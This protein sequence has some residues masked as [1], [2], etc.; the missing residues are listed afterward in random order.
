M[1]YANSAIAPHDLLNQTPTKTAKS[2]IKTGRS[3]WR[4]VFD[5]LIESRMRQ[6]EREIAR[7][8]AAKSFSDEVEREIERRFLS[9]PSHW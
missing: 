6:A 5:A 3:L 8:M 7:Y 9:E 2:K 1:A 4:R